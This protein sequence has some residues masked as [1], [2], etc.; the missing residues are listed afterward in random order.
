MEEVR[1][2]DDR[3]AERLRESEGRRT[4]ERLGERLAGRLHESDIRELC[5]RIRLDRLLRE[6]L[7]ETCFAPDNRSGANA[8]WVFTHAGAEDRQ[9]LGERRD[10]LIDRVLVETDTTRRRLLLNLLE[11]MPYGE[12][13]LRGD[14][15]DFCLQA[16]C[17]PGETAGIR[18]LCIKL[19]YAQCRHYAEL[20]GELSAALDVIDD[21][22]LSP[23]VVSARQRIRRQM[24]RD[25]RLRRLKRP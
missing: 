18:C 17:R 3:P 8:L 4:D 7:Y 5:E 23:A 20:R 11:R 12:A 22:P 16:I 10:A 25:A 14:F 9:W 19:A 21:L 6:E 1:K 2:R 15:I 13:E 24:E